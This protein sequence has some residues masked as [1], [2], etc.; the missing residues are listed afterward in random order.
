LTQEIRAFM[1]GLFRQGAFAGTTAD[2]A[3]H[4]QCDASTTTPDDVANGIVNVI[5]SF[6][7]LRPAEFVVIKISQLAGQS[8]G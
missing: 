6:A 3:F 2:Q 7:P 8:Q 5:V 1:L 4:V